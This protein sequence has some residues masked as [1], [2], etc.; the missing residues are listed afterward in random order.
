M[1]DTNRT[2]EQE[3]LLELLNKCRGESD[4]RRLLNH[5]QALKTFLLAHLIQQG[6]LVAQLKEGQVVKGKL[7]DKIIND[8]DGCVGNTK[9]VVSQLH[10]FLRKYEGAN[11]K[12]DSM[13]F[14]VTA[15]HLIK[16]FDRNLAKFDD[17]FQRLT[18]ACRVA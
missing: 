10:A 4:P 15:S 5:M 13:E 1:S 2:P 7:E 12:V 6:T 11:K 8:C 17:L 3:H 18:D 14:R 16:Q 9:K